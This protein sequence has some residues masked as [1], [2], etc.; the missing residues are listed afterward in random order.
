MY[1]IGTI[2]ENNSAKIIVSFENGDEPKIFDYYFS[3]ADGHLKFADSLD[4]KQ[5][6]VIV[7]FA[8]IIQLSMKPWANFKKSWKSTVIS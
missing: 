8:S 4:E 3:I 7:H 1:G 6:N 2:V 5:K